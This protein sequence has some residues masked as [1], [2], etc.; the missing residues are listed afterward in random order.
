MM[1]ALIAVALTLSAP[2]FATSPAAL[3]ASV[4]HRPA[5]AGG[6]GGGT[7]PTFQCSQSSA[8]DNNN[9]LAA[10]APACASAGTF[11]VAVLTQDGAGHTIA[12]PTGWSA[13][14]NLSN[15]TNGDSQ[16][17]GWCRTFA[18]GSDS[19]TFTGNGGTN[20]AVVIFVF[21]GVN[22]TTPVDVVGT[23]ANADSGTYPSSPITVTAPGIT[24]TSTDAIVY[25][26][27]VD[28][29]GG[30]G[31]WTEGGSLSNLAQVDVASN[32]TAMAMAGFAQSSAGATGDQS[33]TWTSAGNVGNYWA[34]L[35]AIKGP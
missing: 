4:L 16:T 8:I 34:L 32:Y 17:V 31:A 1:R 10:T 29:N 3:F 13:V 20:M 14:Q 12:C 19:Y 6:G 28:T 27:L 26:A 11:L 5:A 15:I 21:S 7:A 22:T 9:S 25:M 33:A 35:I 18:T 2:C 24:T 30:N 23:P